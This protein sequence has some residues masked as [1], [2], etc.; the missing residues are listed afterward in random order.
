[1]TFTELMPSELGRVPVRRPAAPIPAGLHP[2]S[3]AYPR[4]RGAELTA[5]GTLPAG[6]RPAS[7]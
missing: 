2:T 3:G 6:P 7:E 4:P 5:P 1:M